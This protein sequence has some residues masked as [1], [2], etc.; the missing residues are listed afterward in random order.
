MPSSQDQPVPSELAPY[1]VAW[2]TLLLRDRE[3]IDALI[4]PAHAGP[5]PDLSRALAHWRGH[6]YWS[7][8]PGGRWLILT[9]R[10]T[11]PAERWWLHGLLLLATLVTT[12]V[13]GSALRGNLIIDDAWGLLRGR[14]TVLG[15]PV[16]ALASG[17]VFSVPLVAM[18]LRTCGGTIEQIVSGCARC[19]SVS[20]LDSS[21]R[22]SQP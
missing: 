6:H 17:L 3:V 4:H 12:T 7:D 20:M 18:R 9:R 1:V 13:A 5:S 16:A 10:R 14:V 21:L 11:E 22:A 19:R 15:D 8:E 2:R